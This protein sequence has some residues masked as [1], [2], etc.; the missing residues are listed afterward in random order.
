MNDT[1]DADIQPQL[2]KQFYESGYYI[3]KLMR[4]IFTADWFYDEK[5]IGVHIK[6]P[7][8]LIT[9]IRRIIPLQMQDEKPVLFAQKVLGQVL[10]YPPNVAGWAGGRSWIDS[11]SLMFRLKMPEYIFNAAEFEVTPKDDQDSIEAQMMMGDQMAYAPQVTVN[12]LNM[13]ADWQDYINSFSDLND[14]QLF[15]EITDYLIQPLNRDV[16]TDMLQNYAN[17]DSRE[18]YI[19][20]LT[21][22]VMSL[23][24]YQLC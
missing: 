13:T 16:S 22:R 19:K 24:E 4:T 20:S 23:P 15:D 17:T 14:K 21:V 7:V 1:I 5:N 12:K 6:S 8:E 11:S 2:A 9:G 10:F 18:G 3:E